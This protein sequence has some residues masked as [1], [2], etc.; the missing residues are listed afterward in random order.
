MKTQGETP[1]ADST[2]TTLEDLLRDQLRDIYSVEC[3]LIPALAELESMATA[4]S[5]RHHLREHTDETREQKVRLEVIGHEHGWK[6]GGDSSKAM[7]GLIDGGH[8]H[9]ADIKDAP[10]RDFLIVAH[11]HRV[12]HYEIAAYTV[13]IAL[14]EKLGWTK[15][16]HRLRAS[17]REEE[18]MDASLSRLVAEDLLDAIR[19]K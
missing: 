14:A 10:A 4:K 12:E 15:E 19:P 18:A 6:L 17:L 7:A 3:Q 5:L 16:L 9:V 11:S 2:S 1:P 13:I 8:S